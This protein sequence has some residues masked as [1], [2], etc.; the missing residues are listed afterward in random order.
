MHRVKPG[1]EGGNLKPEGAIQEDVTRS[2]M[3]GAVSPA[4]LI[5]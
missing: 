2:F 4:P 3:E 1:D 5:R